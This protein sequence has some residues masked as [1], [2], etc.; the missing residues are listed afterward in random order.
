LRAWGPPSG[1]ADRFDNRAN[2][3]RQTI[4][5]A[6]SAGA[7]AGSTMVAAKRLVSQGAAKS[8]R[9]AGFPMPSAACA[10]NQT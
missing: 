5:S 3:R 7:E 9:S 2:R 4:N 10:D 1:F 6:I 8:H